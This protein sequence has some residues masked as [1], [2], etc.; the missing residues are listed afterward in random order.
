MRI[1]QTY[2]EEMELKEISVVRNFR[3][4]ETIANKYYTKTFS[5]AQHD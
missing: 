4:T 3:T 5:N 2:F 1:Y